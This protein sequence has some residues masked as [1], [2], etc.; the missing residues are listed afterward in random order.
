MK[1]KLSEGEGD[2]SR[3]RVS[4]EGNGGEQNRRGSSGV[5]KG[6]SGGSSVSRCARIRLW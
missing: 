2:N 4:S 5:S 3:V 6:S 1:G